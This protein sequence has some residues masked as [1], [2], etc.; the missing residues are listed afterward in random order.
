MTSVV[1]SAVRSPES[2]ALASVLAERLERGARALA[3][4]ASTLTDAQWKTPVTRGGRTV[5]VVVHHVA[6]VYPVEIQLAQL[7]AGGQAINDVTWSVIHKM[8]ADHAAAN[9]NVTKAEAIE[10][11]A[12]NSKIGRAHV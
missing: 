3:S 10:L 11:L 2:T 1:S 9:A 6:S 5:G 8:N 7:L 12:R 4:L